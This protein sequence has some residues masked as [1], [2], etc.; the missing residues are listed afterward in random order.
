MEMIITKIYH[1][2]TILPRKMRVAAYARVSCEKDAALH[3]LSAQVTYYSDLIQHKHAWE[4]AGV[5]V[6]EAVTGTKDAREN[7]Q[8]LLADCRAGKIDLILTK[9]ISRFARNTII[10]LKT[11]RELKE[12]QV[13]VFFERENIHSIS[14]DGELILTILAAYAE[15]ESISTS[16]NCKWHYQKRFAKGELAG[17]NF[18]YGYRVVQG[19]LVVEPT[20]ADIVR[21]IFR[22]YTNG[23]G[24]TEI[25][26]RLQADHVPT[27]MGGQWT[28]RRLQ[29]VLANEKYTGDA[30][31]QKTFIADPLTKVK[32]VNKGEEPQYFAEA[33]HEAIIDKETFE[34]ARS[35]RAGNFVK[36]KVKHQEK[37]M[38]PFTGKIRCLQCGAHYRRIKTHAGF[39]WNCESYVLFG[40]VAC[41]T[42]RIPE[43]V[44]LRL[45]AEVLEC[46][47]FDDHVFSQRISEI[48]VPA[49]NKLAFVFMDGTEVVR[50]W[51]DRSRRDSWTE[52]MK[53][54]ARQ[55]AIEQHRRNQTHASKIRDIHSCQ[56]A[57]IGLLSSGSS[58]EKAC[59]S[60]CPGVD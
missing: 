12:L 19:Q 25:L 3:S 24:T 28:Q 29:D 53:E 23:I 1:P 7:F 27:L 41:A 6:D 59:G 22:D 58:H 57:E 26:R 34:K 47:A 46:P 13:D 60:I 35:I 17:L 44:L 39:A 54:K 15:Q 31:L 49:F 43:E 11:V 45:S 8:R 48:D 14:D 9:S 51:N 2:K 50:T 55:Q 10:F 38:R 40:K 52:E 30:L 56:P 33:T 16:Q 36:N 32:K 5:Y 4:Y 42:K 20:E 18:L 37:I 21:S